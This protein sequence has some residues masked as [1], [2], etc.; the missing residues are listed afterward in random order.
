MLQII[1]KATFK[2]IHSYYC[3]CMNCFTIE[4]LRKRE[5]G[6]DS[7]FLVGQ[8]IPANGLS[9]DYNI[10]TNTA[11]PGIGIYTNVCLHNH[12]S[13]YLLKLYKYGCEW[14]YLIIFFLHFYK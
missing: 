6:N 5:N 8:I 4:Y 1:A 2:Q 11:K 9:H 10:L 13:F 7:V 14:F 3:A 12:F